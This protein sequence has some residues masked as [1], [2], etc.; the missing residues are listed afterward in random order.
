M[1]F[2]STNPKG[3][4]LIVHWFLSICLPFFHQLFPSGRLLNEKTAVDMV[5]NPTFC[6]AVKTCTPLRGSRQRRLSKSAASKKVFSY[7]WRNSVFRTSSTSRN[8]F[9]SYIKADG[10][11]MDSNSRQKGKRLTRPT[12]FFALLT[13]LYTAALCGTVLCGQFLVS[14]LS[15]I[16]TRASLQEDMAV[17]WYFMQQR[18]VDKRPLH[19]LEIRTCL[20]T[21]P[22]H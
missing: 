21:S 6:A 8:V 11:K 20:E 5:Q 2:P 1:I 13:T 7:S 12:A 17:G 9:F 16:H 3:R 10:D 18:V 14:V 4:L 19:N 22:L 15:A